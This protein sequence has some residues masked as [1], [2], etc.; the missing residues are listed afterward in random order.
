MAEVIKTLEFYLFSKQYV[1]M[2]ADAA[3]HSDRANVNPSY[4]TGLGAFGQG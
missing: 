3:W 4:L 2:Q 1:M